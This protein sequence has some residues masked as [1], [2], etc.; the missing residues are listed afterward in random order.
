MGAT[1][2]RCRR[3]RELHESGCFIIPN[4]WDIGSARVLEQLGFKALATTSA[5]FA[6]SIGQA[7]GRVALDEALA[8]YRAVAASVAVPVNADFEKGFAISPDEVA[9]NVALASRTGIAGL[10]VEDSTGK[11]AEPLFDFTLAVERVGAARRSLDDTGTGVLLTAR[12]EGFIVGRPDLRGNDSP[13]G[14][15]CGSRRRLLVRAGASHQGGDTL[16]GS[17]PG[18][19]TRECA[20]EHG[21][22]DVRRARGDWSS[23][24]KC[25]W[26]AGPDSVDGVSRGRSRNRTARH[27][28]GAGTGRVGHG[29]QRIIWVGVLANWS[30]SMGRRMMR[31]RVMAVAVLVAAILGNEFLS[32]RADNVTELTKRFGGRWVGAYEGEDSG[33]VTIV[34]SPGIDGDHKGTLTALSSSGEAY[35][36]VFK[37]LTLEGTHMAAKYDV[38]SGEG[39][40]EGEFDAESGSG[41]WSYHEASGTSSGGTWKVTREA[42][43]EPQ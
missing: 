13:V 27:V 39:A 43:D 34:L 12:S 8:H 40:I 29:D 22:C 7:D 15:V 42:A 20:G 16:N 17:R 28:F 14:G 1:R 25:G 11:V 6:W 37:V 5:G 26:C 35:E 2:D 24:D 38:A 9:N 3:F 30:D 31:K 18:T 32:A 33:R 36:A 41:K 23:K 4:P 21:L 19:Q 10:S